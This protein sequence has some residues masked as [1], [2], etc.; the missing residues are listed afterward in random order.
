MRALP[1]GTRGRTCRDEEVALVIR[2][3]ILKQGHLVTWVCPVGGFLLSRGPGRVTAELVLD[4]ISQ[5]AA[6][7]PS[8]CSVSSTR[9]APEGRGRS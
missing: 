9:P 1:G 3:C 4:L 5:P 8:G 6:P 7:A 2:H